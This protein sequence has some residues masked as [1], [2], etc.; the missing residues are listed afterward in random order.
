MAATV[1]S[2]YP[3][4]LR[5]SEC[6]AT[7]SPNS[8]AARRAASMAAGCGPPVLVDL[9][10]GRT[11]ER[12]LARPA[13]ETVSSLAQQQDVD[14]QVVQGAVRVRE[15]PR[16]G[17]DG[18]GLRPSLG[19][20]PPPAIV[21]MP[22]ASASCTCEGEMRW[23][24]VSM[25]PAVRMRPSPETTSVDGPMRRAGWDAVGDV[26]FPARPMPQTIPSRIPTSAR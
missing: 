17:R 11:G 12:L 25:P 26:G 23:T 20:V 14:G 19:P 3:A 8:S 1:E 9:V 16:A 2:T 22:A 18:R 4:S 13:A 24:W 15:V 6:R 21:V 5:E 7:C 10:P